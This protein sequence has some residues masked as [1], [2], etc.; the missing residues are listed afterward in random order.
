VPVLAYR[1]QPRPGAGRGRAAQ[2][3]AMLESVELR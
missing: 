2:V 3:R 1:L